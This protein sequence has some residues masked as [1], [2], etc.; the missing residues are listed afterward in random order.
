MLTGL[1]VGVYFLGFGLCG[2]ETFG[3]G[4]VGFGGL[5]FLGALDIAFAG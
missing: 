1:A 4:L 3:T 5:V 2:V